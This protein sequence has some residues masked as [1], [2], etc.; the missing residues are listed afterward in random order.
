MLIGCVYWCRTRRNQRVHAYQK[1]HQPC[2]IPNNTQ[3]AVY[4]G[5]PGFVTVGEQQGDWVP[6]PNGYPQQQYFLVMPQPQQ[7]QPESK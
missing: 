7:L 3:Q 6:V 1:L 4:P 5:N 2:W